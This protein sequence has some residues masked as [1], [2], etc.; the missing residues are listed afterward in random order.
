MDTFNRSDFLSNLHIDD[1]NNLSDLE[2]ANKIN[3]KFLEQLQVPQMT[4][5]GLL[6]KNIVTVN[7]D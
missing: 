5:T 3:D 1:L 2:V 7:H 6:Y 4:T